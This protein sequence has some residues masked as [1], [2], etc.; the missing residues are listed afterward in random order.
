MLVVFR[1]LP[2]T[3]KT[4]LA[5]RLLERRSDLLVLSRDALR[6]AII[7]RPAFDEEEKSFI[8]SL[9]VAM[10]GLLLE[11]GRSVVIDGMALSSAKLLERF[12]ET[13]T[14]NRASIRIIECVCS[15]ATALERIAADQGA[16]PAGDRGADLYY[17]VRDRFQPTELPYLRIDTDREEEENLEA[18]LGYIEN[19]P[20]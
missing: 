14:E 1:G 3:G 9:I 2:G 20:D 17:R 8:D 5:R 4:H 7:P 11:N 18:V 15:E 13:A 10:S 16:H 6:S 19:P 12:A